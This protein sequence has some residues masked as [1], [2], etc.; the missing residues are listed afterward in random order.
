M[1]P[2]VGIDLGMGGEGLAG[3]LAAEL[4]VALGL[5][6]RRVHHQ[7]RA[8]LLER[9]ELAAVEPG[10]GVGGA[11]DLAL[12]RSDRRSADCGRRRTGPGR[13]HAP[14][15]ICRSAPSAGGN[16]T[17]PSWKWNAVIIPSPLKAMSSPRQRRELRVGLDA[18]E[19]AVERAG[20]SPSY[21]RSAMSASIREGV[22]KPVKEG[23]S[24]KLWTRRL[25][26]ARFVCYTHDRSNRMIVRGD[27]S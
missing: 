9:I 11:A 10:V 25:S 12:D 7:R 5:Q 16:R 14:A 13:P 21:V 2:V 18:V 27:G 17:W 15:S 23:V 26:F 4:G 22:L 1:L 20:M 6:R 8:V 24:R 3:H 19:G